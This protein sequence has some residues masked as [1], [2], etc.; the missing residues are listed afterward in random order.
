M[1]GMYGFA[2]MSDSKSVVQFVKDIENQPCLYNTK[3]HEYVNHALKRKTWM[4]IAKKW[5]CTV[6]ECKEKWRKIRTAYSRSLKPKYRD[7]KRLPTRPYYLASYLKFITPTKNSVPPSKNNDIKTEMKPDEVN[8]ML[9]DSDEKID[10]QDEQS[11][12]MLEDNDCFNSDDDEFFDDNDISMDEETISNEN[13]MKESKK[14]KVGN[15][16][17]TIM[18][19]LD[20]VTNNVKSHKIKNN[21]AILKD[22]KGAIKNEVITKEDRK[23]KIR[24]NHTSEQRCSYCANIESKPRKMLLFSLLPDIEALTEQ[25]MRSFRRELIDLIDKCKYGENTVQ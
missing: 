18:G 3:S 16:F 24:N 17:I 11:D 12:E 2:R 4:H 15:N 25:Q 14:V 8:D 23:S 21:H 7:N 9:E 22:R 6:A 13:K 1:S 20:N 5:N 19:S 10:T